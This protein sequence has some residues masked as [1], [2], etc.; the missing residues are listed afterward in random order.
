ML[1]VRRLTLGYGGPEPV[2]AELDLEIAPSALVGDLSPANK[3]LVEIAKA[4]YRRPDLLVLDEPTAMLGA[5]EKQKLFAAVARLRKQG[6]AFIFIT[7]HIEEVIEIGDTV[8]IYVYPRAE[9]VLMIDGD[10]KK[11]TYG[12]KLQ[13]VVLQRRY[14]RTQLRLKATDF[15]TADIREAYIQ[16]IK[17]LLETTCPNLEQRNHLRGLLSTYR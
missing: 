9:T 14:E 17:A 6:T 11:S 2:L 3:Q 7:H 4:L 13:C 10:P 12:A 8:S 1:H 16:A 15:P 5:V